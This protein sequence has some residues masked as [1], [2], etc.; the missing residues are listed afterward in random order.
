MTGPLAKPINELEVSVRVH[1]CLENLGI[2]NVMD[3]MRYSER[4]LLLCPNF[5]ETSMSELRDV[6]YELGLTLPKSPTPFPD[7][8]VP[9]PDL[10]DVVVREIERVTANFR[11]R[12]I[13]IEMRKWQQ[14]RNKALRD[15]QK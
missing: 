2:Q 12:R 8:P 1:N 9:P 11:K 7:V 10:P 6:L 14:K 4:E 3:L 5:G 13:S 15:N